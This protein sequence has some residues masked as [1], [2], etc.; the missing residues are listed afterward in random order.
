MKSSTRAFSRPDFCSGGLSFNPGRCR[1][2][3][4]RVV[5]PYTSFSPRCR[6]TPFR[7]FSHSVIAWFIRPTLSP[8]AHSSR[9]LRSSGPAVGRHHHVGMGDFC[10]FRPG[11]I[12]DHS[13]S[14]AAAP[15]LH[16]TDHESGIPRRSTTMRSPI[17]FA[18][19][20]TIRD[21]SSTAR[22]AAAR[23]IRELARRHIR[24][25]R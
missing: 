19:C 9:P 25:S 3:M 22:Q 6:A 8:T 1:P 20:A 2:K 16:R 23:E 17:A 11:R 21:I 4:A 12:C 18:K 5:T 13:D 10:L 15:G 24:I 7:R 14:L